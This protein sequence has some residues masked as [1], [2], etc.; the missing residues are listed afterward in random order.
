MADNLNALAVLVVL[1]APFLL[2]T[3][4]LWWEYEKMER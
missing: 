4:V 2:F 3:L 1:S